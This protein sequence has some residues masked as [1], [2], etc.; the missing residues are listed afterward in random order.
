MT[1]QYPQPGD[2]N[3]CNPENEQIQ[4]HFQQTNKKRNFLTLRNGSG[5]F[6]DFRHRS[7]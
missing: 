4:S 3:H 7:G 6:L 5:A 1:L 2:A